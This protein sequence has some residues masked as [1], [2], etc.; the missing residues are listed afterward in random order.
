MLTVNICF[1]IGYHGKQH[2]FCTLPYRHIQT[3][4]YHTFNLTRN[5]CSNFCQRL[6]YFRI[7]K[8]FKVYKMQN[9]TSYKHF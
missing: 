1:V 2:S 8:F 3:R 4:N 6:Y 7:L 9:K 5:M